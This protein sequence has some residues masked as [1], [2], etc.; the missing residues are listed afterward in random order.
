MIYYKDDDNLG[1]DF[2]QMHRKCG[3]ARFKV[4]RPRCDCPKILRLV[5]NDTDSINK[6]PTATIEDGKIDALVVVPD[7]RQKYIYLCRD[8]QAEVFAEDPRIAELK[9]REEIFPKTEA[10]GAVDESSFKVSC[11]SCLLSAHEPNGF[12]LISSSSPGDVDLVRDRS[13]ST[14]EE[15]EAGGR[16]L[17]PDHAHFVAR[18][19]R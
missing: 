11:A 14:R 5:K 6:F 2:R 4:H 10:T 9:L 1:T 18:L 15:K 16:S 17:H 12:C 7:T 3:A 19:S 8:T 13:R